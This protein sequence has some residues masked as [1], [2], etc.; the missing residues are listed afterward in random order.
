[1][2]HAEA[3]SQRSGRAPATSHGELSHIALTMFFERGFERTTVDDIARAAGIGRRTFFRY[4]TSKNDLP[5]GEFDPLLL[6]MR[7]R[8]AAIPAEQPIIEALRLAVVHFNRF[9]ADVLPDHRKR[10]WLLLNVPSLTAHSTLK[11]EAWRGVIADFVADRRG[12][13]PNDLTPQT[14]AWACFGLCLA[15]YEQWLENDDSELTELLDAAF[16]TAESI[17][18]FAET[19]AGTLPAAPEG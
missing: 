6:D 4:F 3:A 14:I 7:A 12:E 11:Y 10:M 9:P 18:G 1:M 15:A 19:P 13:R 17:F 2:Q 8:L 5:W 16:I